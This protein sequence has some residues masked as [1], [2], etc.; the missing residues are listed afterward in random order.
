MQIR[1]DDNEGYLPDEDGYPPKGTPETALVIVW[2]GEDY[3][4]HIMAHTGRYFY[5]TVEVGGLNGE[6]SGMEDVPEG[7]G[8]Y[9]MENGRV[10]SHRDWETGIVDEVLIHGDWRKARLADF[11]RFG[12]ECPLDLSPEPEPE[13][14]ALGL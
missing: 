2:S 10:S 11:D 5:G 1:N 8:F 13:E 4:F 14:P 7:P 3:A 12:I 6:E 9:V